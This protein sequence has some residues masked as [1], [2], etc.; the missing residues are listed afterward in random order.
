M[1]GKVKGK[2]QWDIIDVFSQISHIEGWLC[3]GE[4]ETETER[5]SKEDF[6]ILQLI[7]IRFDETYPDF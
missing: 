2:E 6:H 7:W 5:N 4:R 1:S 3:G